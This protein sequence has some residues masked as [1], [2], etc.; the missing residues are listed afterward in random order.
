MGRF[1]GLIR[2]DTCAETLVE[3]HVLRCERCR[4][5]HGRIPGLPGKAG[6]TP[7]PLQPQH[8]TRNP[9]RSTR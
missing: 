1:P 7:P 6:H 9:K 3:P 8:R 4:T 5:E 2:C